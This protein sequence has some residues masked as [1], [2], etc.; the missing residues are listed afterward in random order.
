MI[1]S[2]HNLGKKE[3]RRRTKKREEKEGGRFRA[4]NKNWQSSG[5]VGNF[6]W[7]MERG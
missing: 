3:R 4:P 7:M 6:V 1:I 5:T 2:T